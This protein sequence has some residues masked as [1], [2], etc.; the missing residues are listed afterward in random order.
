MVNHSKDHGEVMGPDS[1]SDS[2]LREF[3]SLQ[4]IPNDTVAPATSSIDG[5]RLAQL[6]A[7]GRWPCQE[8]SAEERTTGIAPCKMPRDPLKQRMGSINLFTP[9]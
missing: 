4:E 5:Q 8:E 2:A 1:G 3:L 9:I 7:T 6:G